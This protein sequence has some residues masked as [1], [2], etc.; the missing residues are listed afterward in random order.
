MSVESEPTKQPA[1]I[2]VNP[3]ALVFFRRSP[4]K[5][6][7]SGV[8][9]LLSAFGVPLGPISGGR[10][11]LR[12][13]THLLGQISVPFFG[14]N[15]KIPPHLANTPAAKEYPRTLNARGAHLTPG[16]LRVLTCRVR[17]VPAESLSLDQGEADLADCLGQFFLACGA[18]NVSLF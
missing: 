11:T 14:E 16:T 18:L 3:C 10:E 7:H 6:T 2:G 4:N 8:L 5:E 17:K 1:T 9:G 15:Q 12:P 13:A